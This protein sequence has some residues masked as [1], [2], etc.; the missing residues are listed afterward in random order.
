MYKVRMMISIF[1]GWPRKIP[2]FLG[3][4]SKFCSSGFSTFPRVRLARDVNVGGI[5][6]PLGNMKI[7]LR[8]VKNVVHVLHE[9]SVSEALHGARKYENFSSS[10]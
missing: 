4:L 9:M 3:D 6:W 8:V 2:G 5:T 1:Q 7:L 10:G